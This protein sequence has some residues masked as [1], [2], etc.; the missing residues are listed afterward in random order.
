[1]KLQTFYDRLPRNKIE[2]VD[3]QT[4]ISGSLRTSQM[5]LQAILEGY[6]AAYILPLV[7]QASLREACI[8]AFGRDRSSAPKATITYP[9][10]APTLPVARM[11]GELM[12]SFYMLDRY[13]VM[14]RDVVVR[15]GDDAFTPDIYVY[16]DPADSR[17]GSYYFDGAPDLIV[18][19]MHPATRAF[20][21][22]LRLS[23]YQAAGVPEIWLIDYEHEKVI[24]YHR[25]TAHRRAG[26]YA[27][28][29]FTAHDIVASRVLPGLTLPLERLWRIKADPWQNYF[30]LVT[31]EEASSSAST[32]PRRRTSWPEQSVELPFAPEIRLTP[33]SISFEQFIAWAPEAKFEWF[34]DRPH[35]GGGDETNLH[36]TGL[37]LMTLGLTESVGLLPAEAWSDYL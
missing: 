33:T 6:G 20:D 32:R 26:K 11:V 1:M 30:D 4:L 8:E 5:V 13:G 31:L 25:Q 24:V 2:L 18:E 23:R 28:H 19:A 17:Q 36:I 3:G 29:T 27:L 9:A 37:L 16:A 22:S 7:D 15:L 21:T 14:G 34:S 35:I 10:V 12:M